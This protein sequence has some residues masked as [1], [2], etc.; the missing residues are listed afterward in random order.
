MELLDKDRVA[1]VA[2]AKSTVFSNGKEREKKRL[3]RVRESS[4]FERG[5]SSSKSVSMSPDKPGSVTST[6]ALDRTKPDPDGPQKQKDHKVRLLVN[7]NSGGGIISVMDQSRL[8]EKSTAQKS[9]TALAA[10]AS[11]E[12]D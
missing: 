6:S 10:L 4:I 12:S 3:R 1:D 11:Y 8:Q 5:P 7:H 2:R 9:T